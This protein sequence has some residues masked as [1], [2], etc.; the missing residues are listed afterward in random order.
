MRRRY[1]LSPDL[2]FVSGDLAYGHLGDWALSIDEQFDEVARFI[3]KVREEFD[4]P[5]PND[6]VFIVPGNHDITRQKVL[7]LLPMLSY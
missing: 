3:T 6:R 2:I 1:S 5:I 7:E 4:P